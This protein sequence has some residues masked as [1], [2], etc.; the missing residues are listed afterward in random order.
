MFIE[1][2]LRIYLLP[3]PPPTKNIAS[4]L[5]TEPSDTFEDSNMSDLTKELHISG[6]GVHQNRANL[7]IAIANSCC[8]SEIAVTY[9]T[10]G[11]RCP[12]ASSQRPPVMAPNLL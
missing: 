5:T 9:D 12:A 10:L 1:H 4:L 3:P 7:A 2:P 6:I 11:G 8:R